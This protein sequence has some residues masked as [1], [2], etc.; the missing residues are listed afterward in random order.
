MLPYSL[1]A[2]AFSAMAG[3][4]VSRTGQY[5]LLMQVSYAIF[6]VGMG[7]MI[8]LRSTSSQYALNTA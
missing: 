1:G 7:L 8:Q 3:L 2:A 4:L 5:R 6:A